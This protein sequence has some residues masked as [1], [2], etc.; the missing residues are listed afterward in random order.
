AAAAVLLSFA[1]PGVPRGAFLLLTPLLTAIG[2][3]A[4]GV[5][6]LI[7]V[8]LIPDMFATV[9]NVT[10][11]VTATALVARLSRDD[12]VPAAPPVPAAGAA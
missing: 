1:A 4:E 10:G 12:V 8:D 11:D 6:V 9:I 7:A 5:G 3:P 2:L